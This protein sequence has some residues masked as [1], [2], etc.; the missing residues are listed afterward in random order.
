M[1]LSC[2]LQRSNNCTRS[3]VN[4]S[5]V[6]SQA[7]SSNIRGPFDCMVHITVLGTSGACADC[8]EQAGDL[9]AA[10]RNIVSLAQSLG[11]LCCENASENTPDNLRPDPD[12]ACLRGLHIVELAQLHE[13]QLVLLGEL[14]RCVEGMQ[15]RLHVTEQQRELQLSVVASSIQVCDSAI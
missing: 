5:F 7:H 3:H 13:E 12:P 8:Q 11:S 15:N 4:I 14:G 9:I 6:L 10:R 2:M 1:H